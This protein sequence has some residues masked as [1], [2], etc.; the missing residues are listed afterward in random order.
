[1]AEIAEIVGC[2]GRAWVGDPNT[3]SRSGSRET[4]TGALRNHV[5]LELADQRDQGEH[6]ADERD[7]ETGRGDSVALRM[8]RC[9][10]RGL[11]PRRDVS[12]ALLLP[13]ATLYRALGTQNPRTSVAT[14]PSGAVAG[15][16]G[17]AG[18]PESPRCIGGGSAG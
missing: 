1:M 8:L 11:V 12:G 16:S 14:G 9:G 6:G 15:H 10:V 7:D 18:L 13:R 5:G 4:V 17:G 2:P 3:P